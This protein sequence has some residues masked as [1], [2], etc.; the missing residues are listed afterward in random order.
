VTEPLQQIASVSD[1]NTLQ[2]D[3]DRLFSWALNWQTNEIQFKKFK[4][5]SISLKRNKPLQDDTLEPDLP[6]VV[7]CAI[8]SLPCSDKLG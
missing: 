1:I 6:T 7:G 2:A 8:V 5:F 3:I 4:V